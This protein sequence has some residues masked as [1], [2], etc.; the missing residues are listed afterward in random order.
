MWY[1]VIIC[2]L[3]IG[4]DCNDLKKINYIVVLLEF[5]FGVMV[6]F[7]EVMYIK[8]ERMCLILVLISI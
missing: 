2:F 4:V 7:F 1:V 8:Y 3:G 6:F 5:F